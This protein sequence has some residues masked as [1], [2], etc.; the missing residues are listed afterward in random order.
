MA[1]PSKLQFGGGF[2]PKTR[3][4]GGSMTNSFLAT[5]LS[6]SITVADYFTL[7]DS[8]IRCNPILRRSNVG[9]LIVQRAKR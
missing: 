9:T 8:Q 3:Y 6:S 4:G 1:K 2:Q 5:K 7:R